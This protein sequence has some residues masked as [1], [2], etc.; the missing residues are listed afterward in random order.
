M[1][2]HNG[3]VETIIPGAQADWSGDGKSILYGRGNGEKKLWQI[4]TRRLD[5]G[6]EKEIYSQPAEGGMSI[7][8]S[9][10]GKWLAF[11]GRDVKRVLKVIPADGG[12][13]RELFSWEQGGTVPIDLT[14]TPDSRYIVFP[15]PEQEQGLT[16]G[17][18]RVAVESGAAKKLD[19]RMPSRIECPTFHPDGKHIAFSS[20]GPSISA[21][22]PE[23][24]VIE[25]FLPPLKK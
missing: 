1:E 9:P 24:W 7:S 5:S 2:V 10:D 21:A 3:A 20:M 25:D 12:N 6:I 11:V 8:V 19:L 22:G 23:I 13:P 16:W 4:V 15:R 18:W 14:W 17:L